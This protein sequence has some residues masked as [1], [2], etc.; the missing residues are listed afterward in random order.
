M[1]WLDKKSGGMVN[2]TLA[3]DAGSFYRD[4]DRSA[5]TTARAGDMY[6][7]KSIDDYNKGSAGRKARREPDNFLGHTKGAYNR[8][9][10][11]MHS[12][13]ASRMGLSSSQLSVLQKSDRAAAGGVS[14]I[15]GERS[16]N[17]T[18]KAAAQFTRNRIKTGVAG[19]GAAATFGIGKMMRG[20]NA[21]MWFYE[22]ASLGMGGVKAIAAVGSQARYTPHATIGSGVQDNHMAATMRQSSLQ[23]MYSSEYGNRR[24]MG[25]EA[26]FLHS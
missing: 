6:L 10:S 4:L 13:I 9:S 16:M 19:K 2:R 5:R 21:A 18:E 3:P 25:N 24:H 15:L 1:S 17:A 7:G 8:G 11:K 12:R 23:D 22:A 26:K 20:A 14:R